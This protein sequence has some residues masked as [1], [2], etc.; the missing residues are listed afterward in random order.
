MVKLGVVTMIGI[1]IHGAR[2]RMGQRISA[3]AASD[4]RFDIRAEVDRDDAMPSV[5]FE[6]VI[7]FS[8]PDGALR[9]ASI[10]RDAGAALVCGTTG[11][12]PEIH[13]ELGD[14]ARFVPVLVAPNTSLGVAVLRHLACEAAR[15][16]GA[17]F[18]VDL[19][20]THHT[21]KRDAPSGTAL[22]IVAD[23]E[24]RAGRRLD[25]EH[26]HAM[27]A[28]DVI[29]EHEII[30][31]GPGERIRVSHVATSRELFARGALEAAAWIAGR[32]AGVYTMEDAFGLGAAV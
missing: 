13:R 10:A 17:R 19:V 5:P 14:C 9:A 2:G 1:A 22:R 31:S 15:L 12:S 28:G 24:E 27:R 16:L 4:E 26:V 18:D 29:G 3:I 30:F 21:A 7:D 23:L 8:Q 20:E 11:L 6:V 25:A 32:S